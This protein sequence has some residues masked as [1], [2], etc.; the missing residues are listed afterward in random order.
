M[1]TRLYDEYMMWRKQ[2]LRAIT[3]YGISKY[4]FSFILDYLL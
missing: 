2:G 1:D 4:G 3:A